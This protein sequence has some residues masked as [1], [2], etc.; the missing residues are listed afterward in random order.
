MSKPNPKSIRPMKASL[1]QLILASVC[2]AT[3]FQ[4][5]ASTAQVP[6]G[7]APPA[8]QAGPL[9]SS[10]QLQDLVGRI[11]LYPDDLLGLVLPASTTPIDIVKAQRFLANY[12]KDKSLKPDPS[13]SQPVLNLMTCPDVIV[14]MGND[15]D[16]TDALGRAVTVLL[17]GC[18]SGSATD[19]RGDSVSWSRGRR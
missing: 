7:Q 4:P 15:L 14:L 13:I 5:L 8:M 17:S 9:L 10:E 18:G 19:W 3:T 2:I 6:P 16:W 12:A 1:S 11:A